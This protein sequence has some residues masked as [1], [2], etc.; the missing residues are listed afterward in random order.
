MDILKKYNKRYA[1]KKFDNSKKLNDNQIELL[2]NAVQLAPTSYG[3]QPF[4][5]VVVQDQLVK[6]ELC[7][8]AYNQPQLSDSSAVFVFAAKK[9]VTHEDIKKFIKHTAAVRNVSEEDL[10]GYHDMMI[11]STDA[12]SEEEKFYWAASQ[13]YITLG[14]LLTTAAMEDLD[15]CPMEGF[16]SDSFNKI[17]GLDKEGYS[18][19]VIAPVGFRSKEDVYAQAPK[20]RKS[21]E[22]LVSFV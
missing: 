6:E 13:A 17:L 20:V 5:L 7:K 4:K 10:K 18:T 12:K 19:V 15:V 11:G 8:A 2:V 21:V 16:N 14:F 9:S 1:T 22:E 3:L